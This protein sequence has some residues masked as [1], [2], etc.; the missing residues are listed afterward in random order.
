MFTRSPGAHMY[1]VRLWSLSSSAGMAR[2]RCTRDFVAVCNFPTDIFFGVT[3][4]P[5]LD[6]KEARTAPYVDAIL[7]MDTPFGG[8]WLT[9]LVGTAL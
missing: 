2:S 1:R 3:L 5:D 7:A 6:L 9:C 8:I 4:F